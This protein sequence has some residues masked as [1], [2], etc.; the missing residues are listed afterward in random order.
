MTSHI[1]FVALDNNDEAI[2]INLYNLM[3]LGTKAKVVNEG[4]SK[5]TMIG[6]K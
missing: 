5:G 4:F 3:D 1:K 6:I 2:M